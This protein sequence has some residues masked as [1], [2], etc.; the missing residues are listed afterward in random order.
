MRG[1]LVHLFVL[2][3]LA[4]VLPP[5]P[6]SAAE[7]A[8]TVTS[9]DITVN[10]NC[11]LREAVQ[12]TNN[13]ATVDGCVHDGGSGADTIKLDGQAYVLS[14][15][16]N[17]TPEDNL[18]G[19]LDILAGTGGLTIDGVGA[20]SIIDPNDTDRAV[21]VYVG[22]GQVTISNLTVQD[23]NSLDPVFGGGGI[24]NGNTNVSLFLKGVTVKESQT[25]QYGGGVG[26]LGPLSVSNST[27]GPFNQVLGGTN[28]GGGGIYAQDT[29]TLTSSNVTSNQAAGGTILGGGVRIGQQAATISD[30]QI[31]GNGSSGVGA[32]IF[33]DGPLTITGSEISGNQNNRSGGGIAYAPSAATLTIVDTSI[34]DN[35]ARTSG[36]GI[37]LANAASLKMTASTVSG[38]GLQ[39]NQTE[40]VTG[41][42]IDVGSSGVTQI[43]DSTI[44]GNTLDALSSGSGGGIYNRTGAN[45]TIERSTISG[46]TVFLTETAGGGGIT[47]HGALSIVNSTFSGNIASGSSL[48]LGGAIR[49]EPGGIATLMH[50]TTADNIAST[51]IQGKGISVNSA[52]SITVRDS[53]VSEGTTNA[54]GGTGAVASG[55]H[56]V[57]R[58]P[59]GPGDCFE[60][61]TD[62]QGADPLLG[63]LGDNGGPTKTLALG[64][65][66]PAIDLVPNAA[67]DCTSDGAAPLSVDQRGMPR[68][69]LSACDAGAFEVQ[70]PPSKAGEGPP[71]G[72]L[73]PSD[74]SATCRG[75]PATIVGTAAS[76]RL[77]GTAKPDV[78]AALAGGDTIRGLGGGDLIC[79]GPG[80]DLLKGGGG[81][82][83]LLGQAGRDRLFG[84]GARDRLNAGAGRRE[85]CDGGGGKDLGKACESKTKIP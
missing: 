19:D 23:G 80:G 33:A 57:E 46:N 1:R 39:S 41:A 77:V 11:T 42:G 60:A 35:H 21:H 15:A 29:L 16:P 30:S 70:P 20:A 65:G 58:T 44:S 45:T 79:G 82:D 61:A 43:V 7:I 54:C 37:S 48:G 83:T 72:I 50:V 28:D 63:T 59:S 24:L 40:L 76:D 3:S 49:G 64:T 8:P 17:A 62:L 10:G 14:I 81:R 67:P 9:D 73:A 26:S 66:S 53:V 52:S 6:A 55:G 75:K 38:N 56:N 47:N 32:G 71:I 25:T 85:H 69:A 22:P 68:P 2:G 84:G 78:I 36:G 5:G 13:N 51:P 34:A 27:I 74:T 18:D 4:S 31:T 12:A